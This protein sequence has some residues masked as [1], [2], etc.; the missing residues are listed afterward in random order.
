MAK[1][2]AMDDFAGAKPKSLFKPTP[3]FKGSGKS[4]PNVTKLPKS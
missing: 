4:K 1:K 2:P 3:P